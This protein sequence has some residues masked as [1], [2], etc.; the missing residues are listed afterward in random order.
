MEYNTT[1]KEDKRQI[2]SIY[3]EKLF[4]VLFLG[5]LVSVLLYLIL[6]FSFWDFEILGWDIGAR[7]AVVIGTFGSYLVSYILVYDGL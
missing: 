5:T 1:Y 7:I 4:L 6:G 3:T 2:K